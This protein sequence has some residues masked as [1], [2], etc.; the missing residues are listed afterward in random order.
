MPLFSYR[1]D[2]ILAICQDVIYRDERLKITAH[3][4]WTKIEDFNKTIVAMPH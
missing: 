1:Q 3:L 2:M 4:R